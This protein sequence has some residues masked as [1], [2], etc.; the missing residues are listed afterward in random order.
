MMMTRA[1]KKWRWEAPLIGAFLFVACGPVP[2]ATAKVFRF[3]GPAKNPEL[4]NGRYGWE[5]AYKTQMTVNGRPSEVRLY[6]ARFDDP[7]LDQ[8]KTRFEEQGAKVALVQTPGGATGVA[9]WPD[10]KEAR[11]L[12][13]SPATEPRQLIFVFYPEL[14]SSPKNVRLPVSKY[15]GST[16]E[17]TV[18]NDETKTFFASFSTMA[19]ATELHTFHA[20]ALA[21]EGWKLLTPALVRDGSISGMAVFQKGKKVCYVQAVNR[22]GRLNTVTLLV[23]GGKL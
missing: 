12:V 16:T 19:S 18:S 8:L 3:L 4:N 20:S 9:L 1:K 14:G 7:V 10:G 22:P 5:S 2:S 13:L 21:A 11:F 6:S 17:F 15:P 23:K